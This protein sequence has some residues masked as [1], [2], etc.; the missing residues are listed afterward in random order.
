MCFSK[1]KHLGIHGQFILQRNAA[2]LLFY[3]NTVIFHENSTILVNYSQQAFPY[4]EDWPFY[5]VGTTVHSFKNSMVTI[6]NS[7]GHKSGGLVLEKSNVSLKGD[8]TWLFM[9]N[10]GRRGGALRLHKKSKLVSGGSTTNLTFINNHASKVGGAIFVVDSDFITKGFYLGDDVYETFTIGSDIY[11]YFKNNTADQA[12][13]A[14]YGGWI[15][16]S[17]SK[18]DFGNQLGTDLSLVS[19]D[20]TKLCLCSNSLSNCNKTVD[21][22][23]LIPSD[24][25]QQ[26]G[27]GEKVKSC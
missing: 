12:G 4:P 18:F 25:A 13:S 3:V 1:C 2:Q 23:A 26:L 5:I 7:V 10:S 19:S 21:S 11:F 9:N 14:I 15:D 8:L 22:V 6:A 16:Q 20:P 17:L 24:D 27:I